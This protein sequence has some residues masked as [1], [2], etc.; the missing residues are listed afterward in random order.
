MSSK[1]QIVAGCLV[2]VLAAFSGYWGAGY[3]ALSLA[4][5]PP[6]IQARLNLLGFSI[7]ALSVALMT[8][9]GWLLWNGIRRA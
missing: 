9:A 1:Q 4:P 3:L 2:L 7:L 6:S 5:A 8:Y